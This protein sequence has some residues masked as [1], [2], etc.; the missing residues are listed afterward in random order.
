MG[1]CGLMDG[2]EVKGYRAETGMGAAWGAGR[3]G[4]LPGMQHPVARG[5][6][7][8]QHCPCNRNQAGHWG[9]DAQDDLGLH[10]GTSAPRQQLRAGTPTS[11]LQARH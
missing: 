2:A 10:V 7:S 6:G 3:H 11:H 5:L 4:C 9:Q 1:L 8:P